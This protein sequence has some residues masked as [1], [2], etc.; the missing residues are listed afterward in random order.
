[1]VA[2][3]MLISVTGPNKKMSNNKHLVLKGHYHWWGKGQ[4]LMGNFKGWWGI[5]PP[6]NMLK[7][8]LDWISPR[9]I[10][11][12]L[13]RPMSLPPLRQTPVNPTSRLRAVLYSPFICAPLFLLPSPRLLIIRND[14]NI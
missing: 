8:A 13:S 4:R 6:V 10:C 12:F 3:L 11:I 5:S 2:P 14:A 1:M 9:E 7:K